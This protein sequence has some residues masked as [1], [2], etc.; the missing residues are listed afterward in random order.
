MAQDKS[1]EIIKFSGAGGPPIEPAPDAEAQPTATETESEAPSLDEMSTGVFLRT[2]RERAHLTIAA[3]S[4]ATKV[5]AE[6]L[7][8]IEWMRLDR[9]PALPYAIGFVKAY[10]RHL[11]LDAEAVAIQFKIESVALAPAPPGDGAIAREAPHGEGARLGSVFAMMAVLLFALWVGYQ[12]LIGGGGQ[13]DAAG[14]HIRVEPRQ[15]PA[16]QSPAPAE[17]TDPSAQQAEQEQTLPSAEENVP[18][19]Q[20]QPQSN[21]PQTEEIAPPAEAV[22]NEERQAEEA[23]LAPEPRELLLPRR[24]RPS[25]EP[26][27]V[28]PVIIGAELTRPVAPE[29]PDR[30]DRSAADVES[31]TIRFDI[32]V[33]GRAINA[34]VASSSN[35]CFDSEALRT[36]A[37][38]R[39]APRT[40]DGV[41]AVESNKKATLNF[42]K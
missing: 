6:H 7:E 31:V 30:C 25:P 37:R 4:D 8:A 23:S 26:E 27:I 2:A 22:V 19:D 12:V 38:W 35:A 3:V 41:A 29:Y 42:R 28:E 13:Q 5:K 14:P 10:A 1:A 40:V 32:S 39:F 36:V 34:R 11:G 15:A 33:E 9:L 20:A 18:Q 17:M 24:V 16:Q 21:A